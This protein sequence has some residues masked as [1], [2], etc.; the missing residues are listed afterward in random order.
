V[1]YIP[2]L[3]D[4]SALAQCISEA[5]PEVPG[6]EAI[7]KRVDAAVEVGQQVEDSLSVFDAAEHL[8]AD[9]VVGLQDLEDEYWCP[10]QDKD[11]HHHYQHGDNLPNMSLVPMFST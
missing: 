2:L 5:L 9:D 6:H 3:H 10:A 7:D 8:D 11:S 4:H 1:R